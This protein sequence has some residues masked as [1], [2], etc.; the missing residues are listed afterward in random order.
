MLDIN[1]PETFKPKPN[2]AHIK[3]IL[4]HANHAD[5]M[6]KHRV[7]GF[8]L[9]K[10]TKKR[11]IVLVDRI[12]YAFKSEA[13]TSYRSFFILNKDTYA[14][15]TDK[16]TGAPFCIEIKKMGT[17]ESSSWF[18]QAESADMMKIW[19][20]KIKRTIGLIRKEHSTLITNDHL[21][22]ITTEEEEYAIAAGNMRQKSSASLTSYQST[23]LPPQ[24]PP[25]KT[26]PPP[27]PSNVL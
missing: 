4:Q 24:L 3:L 25:P 14:F 13:P 8:S 20:D 22:Q 1:N 11:Y 10:S 23:I 7:P 12:L 17:D 9:M 27:I 19:L 18:L 15:A 16:F 26:Q 5:W 2:G 21:T 6:T